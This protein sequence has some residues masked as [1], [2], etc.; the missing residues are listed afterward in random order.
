[1][2][3][4]GQ[5]DSPFVRR[6][7][8]ALVHYGL[9]FE[10]RP[11]S[12]WADADSIA[13]FNPLRRV[14]VLVLDGGEALVESSAILDAIDD[15]VPAERAL[16]PRSGSVRRAVLRVCALATGVADKAVSLLY[17]GVL[18]GDASNAVWVD[19]CRV[20]M[21]DTLGRLESERAAR[22]GDYWFGSLSH[23]DVALACAMRF[24]REAHP[25]LWAPRDYPVLSNDAE[26]CE[27]TSLFESIVQPLRVQV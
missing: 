24:A 21:R 6:V 25:S 2:I 13:P 23:A 5:Y 14:P 4:I 7:G 9:S 16:V 22:G 27:A 11:W 1:M 17:E 18:R 20:Q 19:R 8:I 12:V 15:M 10:H 26:R 3:L